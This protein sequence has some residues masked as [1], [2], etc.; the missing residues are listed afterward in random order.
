MGDTEYYQLLGVSPE[1]TEKEITRAYRKKALQ[2]HPDKN[3][4]K[5]AVKI[6]HDLSKA[7]EILLDPKAKAAY[8]NVIKAR[9]AK[10]QRDQK[11]DDRRKRLK[12]DLEAR[13]K[14]AARPKDE[15]VPSGLSAEAAAEELE[16]EIER[17]R[18][19]GFKR[20][21]REQELIQEEL[22][23]Q[24]REEKV[25]SSSGEAAAKESPLHRTLKIRWKG[26]AGDLYTTE[27]LRA[28]LEKYGPINHVL[29][30][31]KKKG[32]AV[33]EFTTVDGARKAMA[34]EQGMKL[35]WAAGEP[36][37]AVASGSE[38]QGGPQAGGDMDYETAVLMRMRQTESAKRAAEAS[39]EDGG[40]PASKQRDFE[41]L[42]VMRLRQEEERKRLIAQMMAEEDV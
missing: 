9:Q 40:P 8:D 39:K 34:L 18:A 27:G 35:S 28:V 4:S 22:R 26:E 7:Y 14:Q 32:S 10:A 5:E 20:V 31:G 13:E 6:F 16:K 37:S 2:Y 15:T 36:P 30:S 41:S 1:A 19:E 17:L 3:P 42:T 24:A 29:V 23:K 21:Q 38:P 11:L 33:V 12:E 25:V